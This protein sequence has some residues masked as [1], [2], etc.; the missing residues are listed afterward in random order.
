MGELLPDDDR[1]SALGAFIRRTGI[2]ELPQLIN[3]LL[4]EMSFIGPRPFLPEYLL[5]YSAEV[6]K[7]HFVKPGITGLAQVNGGN[8]LEWEKRF[9]YDLIYVKNISLWQDLKIVKET[10]LH[11]FKKNCYKNLGPYNPQKRSAD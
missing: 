11:L 4:G 7:R 10:A 5:L 1:T 6:R 2:D 8:S 9:I 3:I